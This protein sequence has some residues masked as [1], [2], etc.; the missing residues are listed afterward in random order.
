MSRAW[1]RPCLGELRERAAEAD[2]E[3]LALTCP[4]LRACGLA[5]RRGG[6]TGVDGEAVV[7]LSSLHP[8]RTGRRREL[9]AIAAVVLVRSAMVAPGN[10]ACRVVTEGYAAFGGREVARISVRHRDRA[11]SIS[12]AVTVCPAHDSCLTGLEVARS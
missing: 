11:A 1:C 2:D 3:V 10:V 4:A 9:A 8:A 7:A 6:G 5:R 12:S